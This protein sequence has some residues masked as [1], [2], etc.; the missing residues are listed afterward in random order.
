MKRSLIRI[1]VLF[2][3]G[4]LIISCSKENMPPVSIFNVSPHQGDSLTV[5]YFDARKTYDPESPDYGIQI[6]WDWDGDAAWDTE[7]S[8]NKEYAMRFNTRGQRIVIMEAIDP[9]G[10][11]STTQ[12]TIVLYEDNPFIDTITDPRDGN[13]YS[14]ARMNGYWIMTVLGTDI[15]LNV[16]LG[17][18]I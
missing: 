8:R 10:I 12:D 13:I 17:W 14:I 7:Y 6:R 9:E 11:T 2:L 18:A 15:R 3:S 16:P 4:L 1:I 5:F